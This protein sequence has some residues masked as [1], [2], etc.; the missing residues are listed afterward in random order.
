ML[1]QIRHYLTLNWVFLQYSSLEHNQILRIEEYHCAIASPLSPSLGHGLVT[2]DDHNPTA[3]LVWRSRKRCSD[4]YKCFC[5]ADHYWVDTQMR[6]L[7]NTQFC[8]GS[9]GQHKK[10]KEKKDTISHSKGFLQW[11]TREVFIPRENIPCH[12]RNTKQ[13][14]GAL[15]Q[16]P[17]VKE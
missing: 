3:K 14:Q 11:V 17:R 15:D 2:V 9:F 4:V 1:L 13:L 7:S 8:K 10:R 5:K 6:S 16:V 12:L